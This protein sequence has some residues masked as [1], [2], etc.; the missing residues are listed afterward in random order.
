MGYHKRKITKGIV[1]EYSKIREEY[2]ELDDAHE[3][4]IPVLE[5][6]EC[7]DLI[8]AISLYT[9]NKYNIDIDSLV[10]MSKAT[11]SAFDDGSRKTDH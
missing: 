10:A 1:G 11:K 9:L 6:V 8:G 5:L 3:Q 7:A 4:N 2:Q